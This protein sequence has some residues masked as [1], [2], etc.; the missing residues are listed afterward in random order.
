MLKLQ[1]EQREDTSSDPTG[2]GQKMRVLTRNAK[3]G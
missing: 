3:A 2:A 1:H